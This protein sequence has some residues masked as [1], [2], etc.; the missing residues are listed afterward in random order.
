VA[1]GIVANVSNVIAPFATEELTDA[2]EGGS[3]IVKLLID[4]FCNLGAAGLMGGG[5]QC[6]RQP[7]AGPG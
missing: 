7:G 6:M 3:L 1:A 4:Y 5:T 2:T